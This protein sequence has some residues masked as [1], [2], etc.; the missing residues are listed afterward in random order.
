MMIFLYSHCTRLVSL[1]KGLI[2]D[3]KIKIT[4]LMTLKN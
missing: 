1:T 2:D 3:Y 4:D